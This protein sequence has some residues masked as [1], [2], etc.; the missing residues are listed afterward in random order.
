MTSTTP[1]FVLPAT[2]TYKIQTPDCLVI[3]TRFPGIGTGVSTYTD[4]GDPLS[5]L[6]VKADDPVVTTDIDGGTG[7][8]VCSEDRATSGRLCSDHD[9][10]FFR[11]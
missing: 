6:H 7:C 2:G 11:D 10:K 1:D 8:C 4:D 3:I 9:C 5:I